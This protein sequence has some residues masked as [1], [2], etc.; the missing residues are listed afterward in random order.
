LIIF[1]LFLFEFCYQS[2]N[3]G[4]WCLRIFLPL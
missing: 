1:E 3:D 4:L 2:I